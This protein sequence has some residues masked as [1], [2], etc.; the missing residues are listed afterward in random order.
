MTSDIA[1]SEDLPRWATTLAAIL[2]SGAVFALL[3][4]LGRGWRRG[5]AV[6]ISGVLAVALLGAAVVRPVTVDATAS[7]VGPKVVVL[8]DNSRRMDLP[9]EGVDPSGHGAG[10]C[11]Q[12]EKR[13]AWRALRGAGFF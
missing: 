2:C 3:Y 7:V 13:M 8:I 1:L 4:E 11:C 6:A 5:L 12:V 10:C 9:L